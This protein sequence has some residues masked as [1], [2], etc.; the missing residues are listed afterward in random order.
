MEDRAR[1]LARQGFSFLLSDPVRVVY[2]PQEGEEN[3]ELVDVPND[4]KTVG[5]IVM[6]GNIAMKEVRDLIT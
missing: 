1:F 2:Q 6:R 4:G 5:E 3:G